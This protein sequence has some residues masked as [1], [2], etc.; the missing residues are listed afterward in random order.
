[1]DKQQEF[2]PEFQ[3]RYTTPDGSIMRF[4]MP[5]GEAEMDISYP[6]IILLDFGSAEYS[7]QHIP[8]NGI[9][10][11]MWSRP[12]ELFFHPIDRGLEPKFNFSGDVWSTGMVI[13]DMCYGNSVFNDKLLYNSVEGTPAHEK[14]QTDFHNQC[15]A[16]TSATPDL[17]SP[18]YIF[19][20]FS[21]EARKTDVFA[22]NV[23][24]DIGEFLWRLLQLNGDPAQEW[25]AAK[26]SVLYENVISKYVENSTIPRRRRDSRVWGTMINRVGTHLDLEPDDVI[27]I[28]SL[29]KGMLHWDPEKRANPKTLILENSFFEPLEYAT[30]VFRR[31]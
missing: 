30:N 11:A 13:L 23:W 27:A 29:L 14:F 22:K 2:N 4:R 16:L 1:L 24:K 26:N 9:V 15:L 25:P 10:T 6:R 28:D 5:Y 18:E 3:Y 20:L 19:W 17:D 8:L 21:C 7:T 31:S 12:P